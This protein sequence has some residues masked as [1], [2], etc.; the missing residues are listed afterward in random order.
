MFWSS[1]FPLLPLIYTTLLVIS[2]GDAAAQISSSELEEKVDAM[3]SE[4]YGQNVPGT[5]IVVVKDGEILLNKGY[6]M[7]NLE[8]KVAV[9]SATVFDLASV[10]K[11]FAGFAISTL[12]EEGKIDLQDDIRKY[13][14]ELPD[15]GHIVTVDQL[16]HHTSGIRDWTSTLPLAGWSFDDV[17][18]ME[19]ILRMAQHQKTLNFVP[20]SQYVYSNT[21][22]N[23]LAE[24]VQRVTG[25][26]F[27]HWTKTHIFEPLGMK[28]TRFLD[29]HTALIPNRATGYYRD[30]V[31]SYHVAT[32]NLT[33]LGSSSMF[34]TTTDLAQ[35]AIHLDRPRKDMSSVVDRMFT[36][37][38]LNNGDTISYAFGLSIDDVNGTQWIGHG[39][40]WASFRT[41]L[42]HLPEYHLSVVILKNEPSN[43]Y[44]IARDIASLFLPATSSAAKTEENQETEIAVKVAEKILEEY[45]GTYRLGPAWYVTITRQGDRLWTQATNESSYPMTARSDSLFWIRDYGGRTMTFLRS[46]KGDVTHV[47]YNNQLNPRVGD[48]DP[49]GPKDFEAYTGEYVS[50]ELNTSYQVVIEN[51]S[52]KMKHF[53]HGTLDLTRAW[54]DD[55]TGSRW[56]VSSVEF[57]RDETGEVNSIKV[58]Q[59]RAR[60]QV[61]MKVR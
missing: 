46:A 31:G 35:W 15:F 51:G 47:K 42:A 20:G 2:L 12:V 16:V 41:Y 43:T 21:G 7:A 13:I 14:P 22:Y 8:H 50:R 49:P 6:G 52:L 53:R 32:N 55:F 9:T 11:Q 54:Q 19:Q 30:E 18:S 39:G 27:A 24:L 48:G 4:T 3:F 60:D 61:F 5:A 40:S 44:Q 57:Q 38:V 59:Y 23:L 28:D 25:Q 34:S 26:S 58:W 45:T 29:D 37:G 33:A 10:S 36:Q 1:K 17:I 56:F